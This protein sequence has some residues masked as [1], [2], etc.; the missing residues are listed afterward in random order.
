M[1]LTN[2]QCVFLSIFSLA[3][4]IY[5]ALV[6]LGFPIYE[7]KSSPTLEYCVEMHFEK[8]KE[9]CTNVFESSSPAA[10]S[11]PI[12]IQDNTNNTTTLM[13]SSTTT[14]ST[15]PVS[16]ST[17]SPETAG[18]ATRSF[19]IRENNP[20]WTCPEPG[21]GRGSIIMSALVDGRLGNVV[22]SYLSVLL[23]AQ[24]YG[25]RP[26]LHNSTIR[27]LVR[28]AF[29]IDHIRMPTLEWLDQKCN[30]S[31]WLD[32]AV[33]NVSL[34]KTFYSRR[35]L[36][37]ALEKPPEKGIEMY[38]YSYFVTTTEMLVPYFYEMKKELVLQKDKIILAQ[39]HLHDVG[40]SFLQ[41]LK[42]KNTSTTDF[43]FVGV[44]V[45]RTDFLHHMDVIFPLGKV[46]T[47]KFFHTAME[48]LLKELSK[49]LVFVVVSD[50]RNWTQ[51]NI[52]AERKDVYLGGNGDISNPGV[53]LAILAA[54]N[55]T[56]FAYGTF[57]LT[58]A[59]LASR[60]GGY[61]IVFDPENRTATKEM[62]FAAN[63][64][65]WR[66]MTED[67]NLTYRE[68]TV[69]YRYYLHPIIQVGKNT[70]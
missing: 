27:F 17:T 42:N 69:N 15:Q 36:H 60:P 32:K 47:P 48:W 52:V 12:L 33:R 63:L 58:G 38:R 21:K 53:D 43:E 39:K 2:C 51:A 61:A 41:H 49:P 59:F 62:E 1:Y 24:I 30:M 6:N 57:G 13:I 25:L 4:V 67:G 8:A 14:L 7:C 37:Q 54:C 66:I 31:G 40:T 19:D 26:V 22:W 29:D 50:D 20:W 28:D 64:P 55:H 9:M 56:I 46:A 5:V 35:E 34:C 70:R 45:R 44:H 23:T 18:T 10:S 16:T 65:G 3:F 11:T 68:N